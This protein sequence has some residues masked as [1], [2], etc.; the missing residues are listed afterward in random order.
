MSLT[1]STPFLHGRVGKD[2][3]NINTKVTKR[4]LVIPNPGQRQQGKG[5]GQIWSGQLAA[6]F[7]SKWTFISFMICQL[8]LGFRKSFHSQEVQAKLVYV[9]TWRKGQKKKTQD[10]E[11]FGGN[12]NQ[13]LWFWTKKTLFV[14]HHHAVWER[15]NMGTIHQEIRNAPN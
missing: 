6:L 3:I 14:H 4:M 10:K 5:S 2:I 9:H 13:D 1:A 11:I 8:D 15:G 7:L 12:K